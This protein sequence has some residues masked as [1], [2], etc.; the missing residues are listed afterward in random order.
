MV[1]VSELFSGLVACA[2]QF[3]DMRAQLPDRG[4]LL[5]EEVAQ[6]LVALG[7]F[8]GE[9][10]EALSFGKQI[11]N[12]L[13]FGRSRHPAI[14]IAPRGRRRIYNRTGM[15]TAQICSPR[16]IVVLTGA[17]ISAE[18]GVATFRATDGLWE[19]HR[20]EDVA[21]PEGYLRDP[22]LVHRFYNERRR[23][24][25]TVSPNPAHE[26]LAALERRFA[27]EVL[28]VTQN[29]DDLHERAGTTALVHMHGELRKGRCDRC[30]AV[31][32][33]DRDLDSAS[34]CRVCSRGR[35]RP[36]VVWFGEMP[37]EMPRICAAL[38]LC[39]LFIAVGT[40]GNVF[41]A[42]GFGDLARAA[43]AHCVEVNTQS[44]VSSDRFD[45]RRCGPASVQL[46]ALLEEIA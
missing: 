18:S 28:V 26:S 19:E 16:R 22:Q 1:N 17:G 41:P 15:C 14:I 29:I 35:L 38:E 23:R 40:S 7:K 9:R 3:A 6:L 11:L 33:A 2:F 32:E 10:G 13:R 20:I 44:T 21:T 39:D 5:E 24:L 45:E 31:V 8:G 25:C 36:H 46:V 34:A 42:A 37:L 30:A 4:L 12:A 27:G 43:G